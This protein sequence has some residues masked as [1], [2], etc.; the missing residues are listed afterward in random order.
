MSY[1]LSV[2]A[3]FSYDKKS[4][5]NLPKA[6]LVSEQFVK[7]ELV[8]KKGYSSRVCPCYEVT[9][10]GFV[11]PYQSKLPQNGIILCENIKYSANS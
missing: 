9:R 3:S 6:K 1:S 4:A 10:K 7:K 8:T 5:C 11:D 2:Q